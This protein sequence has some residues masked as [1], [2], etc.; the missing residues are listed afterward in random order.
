M[1][2][3]VICEVSGLSSG[4][5]FPCVA[6]SCS[7]SQPKSKPDIYWPDEQEARGSASAHDSRAFKTSELYEQL[8]N[9]DLSGVLIGDSAY[10]AEVFLLKPLNTTKNV[11]E[12][13]YNRAVCSARA[14]VER[15][16]AVL[17]RQFHILH[18]ECRYSPD[19]AAQIVVACCVLRNI[20]IGQNESSDYDG[21]VRQDGEVPSDSL[22]ETPSRV[23]FPLEQYHRTL[24]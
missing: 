3:S 14:R 9:K 16:F 2:C 15:A 1:S 20:A 5:G 4:Y 11:K 22:V 17:K 13:R 10:G 21:A 23:Q 8:K 6:G 12:E 18:G 24:L 7:S 19:R